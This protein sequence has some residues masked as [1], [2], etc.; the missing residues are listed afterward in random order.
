MGA[1]LGE[2][3]GA[4]IFDQ[5]TFDQMTF[6]QMTQHPKSWQYII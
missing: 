2:G 5:M 6:D 3:M 4:K 1:K